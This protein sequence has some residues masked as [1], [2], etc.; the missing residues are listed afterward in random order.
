[1]HPWKDLSLNVLSEYQQFTIERAFEEFLL[2]TVDMGIE[3]KDIVLNNTKE[4]GEVISEQYSVLPP[5]Q[6]GNTTENQPPMVGEYF[7]SPI[8]LGCL[9]TTLNKEMA[10]KQMDISIKFRPKSEFKRNGK[11]A[12]HT[13]VDR[14]DAAD[15]FVFNKNESFTEISTIKRNAKFS[16]MATSRE[17]LLVTSSM[18]IRQKSTKRKCEESETN[19]EL[20]CRKNCVYRGLLDEIKCTLPWM[21]RLREDPEVPD[22]F[23][24]LPKC[25]DLGPSM[26]L[27]TTVIQETFMSNAKIMH[28]QKVQKCFQGCV[29]SCKSSMVGIP[30][31]GLLTLEIITV[32]L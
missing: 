2:N 11:G 25:A 1:M 23:A 16:V 20:T 26:M 28:N 21:E 6:N 4:G 14:F 19:S 17:R 8:Y 29:E 32:L 3:K 30:T 22:K 5:P 13:S 15:I 9:S 7:L 24:S 10:N 27:E 18:F 31:H 12:Q